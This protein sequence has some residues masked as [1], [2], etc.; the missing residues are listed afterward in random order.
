VAS[1]TQRRPYSALDLPHPTRDGLVFLG[2]AVAAL[3]LDAD[4][5]LPWAAGVA[6]A[7]LFAVAGIVRTAQAHRELVAVRLAADRLI[8]NAPTSRDASE[9][10]RWRAETLTARPER[11]RMQREVGRTLHML[12]P[13]RLPSASPLRRPEARACKELLEQLE[14]RLGSEQPVSAR[15]I[16]LAQVLLRDPASPLYSDGPDQNLAR[17]LRRVVGAL[18]P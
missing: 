6:A 11:D 8:V 12:D 16:V 10:V 3:A 5:S 2:L 18:E 7:A 15:G 9:L 17:A 1:F 4:P 14:A 13:R